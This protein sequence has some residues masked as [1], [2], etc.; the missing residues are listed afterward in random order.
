MDKRP[1]V[2]RTSSEASGY[3]DNVYKDK[4]EQMKKVSAYVLEKGFIPQEL[5]AT[6]VSWFYG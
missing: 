6:E 3:A 2:Q 4:A 1:D 5:V